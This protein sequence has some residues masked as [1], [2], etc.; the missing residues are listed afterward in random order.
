MR[1]GSVWVALAAVRELGQQWNVKAALVEDHKLITSGPYGLVRHPI[2]LGM[3]GMLIATGMANSRWYA[4]LV[5]AALAL[6]GIVIRVQS[7]EKL[8]LEAFGQEFETYRKRVRAFLPWI[9]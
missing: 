1:V 2:Y 7:E 9:F 6:V 3:F 5:A 8:L 4:L